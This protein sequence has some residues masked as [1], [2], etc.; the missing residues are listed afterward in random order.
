M[1]ISSQ[2]V[3]LSLKEMIVKASFKSKEGHIPSGLSILDIIWVLYDKILKIKKNEPNQHDRDRFILSKGH[4]S[5]GLYAVL[6]GQG[7]LEKKLI[8]DF[9][10]FDSILG[11]HPD[12]NKIPFV[13]AST[14][15]LG[16]GL[17]MAVGIAMGAK[18]QMLKS[19]V[20]CLIGDG[21]CNEG[22]IW[23]SMLLAS[24]HK[25]D[26]L[27]CIVDYN[28]STDRALNIDNLTDKFRSF[29]WNTIEVNGHDHESLYKYFS[30]FPQKKELPTVLIAETIKGNGIRS[31]ESQPAWHHKSPSNE[32][33][34]SIIEEI[35]ERA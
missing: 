24:H 2:Q 19:R 1:N 35:Y 10:T 30:E 23:E 21:E 15:S 32:N 17:P 4:G 28:H 27:C 6:I 13:E 33:I 26:N 5:L 12:R 3:I 8:D 29:G 18:I 20:F 25:L 11:G 7:L 22:T 31:M 14:G 9:C 34:K 16:H